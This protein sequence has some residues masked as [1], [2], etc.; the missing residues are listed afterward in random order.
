MELFAKLHLPF[1]KIF[2]IF[3]ICSQKVHNYG[4]HVHNYGTLGCRAKMAQCWMCTFPN[5][6]KSISNTVRSD[7]LS[8]P[9]LLLPATH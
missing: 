6:T 8:F 3:G 1:K 9:G 2:H 4:T 5:K 7:N